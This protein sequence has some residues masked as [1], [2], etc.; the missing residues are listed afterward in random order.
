MKKGNTEGQVM[1][2]YE[3]KITDKQGKMRKFV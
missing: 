1:T 2:M 3:T